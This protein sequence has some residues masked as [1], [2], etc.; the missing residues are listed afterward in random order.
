VGRTTKSD[1]LIR[2]WPGDR[3]FVARVI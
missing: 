3:R 1:G 2:L